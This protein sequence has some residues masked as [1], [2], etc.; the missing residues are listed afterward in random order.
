MMATIGL[1]ACALSSDH[2]ASVNES[3]GTIKT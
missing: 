3:T 1:V 2:F